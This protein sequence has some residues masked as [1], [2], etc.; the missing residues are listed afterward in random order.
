VDTNHYLLSLWPNKANYS[1]VIY[2]QEQLDILHPIQ[3]QLYHL[4]MKV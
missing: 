4:L 1:A 3:S 2:L